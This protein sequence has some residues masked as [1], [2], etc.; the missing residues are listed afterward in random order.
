MPLTF[1]APMSSFMIGIISFH[2]YL[3][4]FL[5]GILIFVVII[6]LHILANSLF[7]KL[8][9]QS[10]FITFIILEHICFC[11]NYEIALVK[12]LD[13]LNLKTLDASKDVTHATL[14]ELIWTLTPS[15]I[16]FLIAIPSF[17]LLY[18]FDEPV[19]PSLSNKITGYQWYW[20]YEYPPYEIKS[21]GNLVAIEKKTILSYISS[22]NDVV[23]K[24]SYRLL[25]TDTAFIL[26]T[27]VTSRLLIT[28]ADVLHSWAV[29]SLGIKMDAVPGRLNSINITPLHEG[30]LYGQC[31]ELCGV[32]HA[33]MPIKVILV[34]L[35]EYYKYI[36]LIYNK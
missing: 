29:P 35:K 18:S 24:R 31:S 30:I 4:I 26:P 21:K 2:N 22:L 23:P 11:F 33:Q 36:H 8:Y 15:F 10:L 28:A 14:L 3:W 32:Q 9:F 16:L 25:E 1:Q 12:N 7:Y 20:G 5:T 34:S 27:D 17:I 19:N 6:L 13:K